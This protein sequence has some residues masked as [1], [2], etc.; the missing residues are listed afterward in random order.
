MKNPCAVEIFIL[1]QKSRLVKVQRMI[2]GSE[3]NINLRLAEQVNLFGASVIIIGTAFAL[4]DTLLAL[5]GNDA[6]QVHNA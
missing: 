3:R 1:L 2:I 6:F 5:R 4:A